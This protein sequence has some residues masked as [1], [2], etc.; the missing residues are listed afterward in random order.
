MTVFPLGAQVCSVSLKG[1]DTGTE[2]L[3]VT[4]KE[5]DGVQILC[6]QE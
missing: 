3:A 6:I 1:A 2:N 5:P 4:Q